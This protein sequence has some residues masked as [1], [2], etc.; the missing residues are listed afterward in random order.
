M[1]FLLAEKLGMLAADVEARMS[2]SEF[3]MW[4][5]YLQIKHEKEKEQSRR[6]SRSPARPR[7]R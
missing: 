4:Q 2:C 1:I 6:A 7:R 3:R 5:E